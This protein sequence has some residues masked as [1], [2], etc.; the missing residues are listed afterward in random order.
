M[1]LALPWIQQQN[2]L[3]YPSSLL[4]LLSLWASASEPSS[5]HTPDVA[6]CCS[7]GELLHVVQLLGCQDAHALPA[8]PAL[9]FAPPLKRAR[10]GEVARGAA[11]LLESG[12]LMLCLSGIGFLI[13]H[14]LQVKLSFIRNIQNPPFPCRFRMGFNKGWTQTGTSPSKQPSMASLLLSRLLFSW[15]LFEINASTY[16]AEISTHR[17]R[18]KMPSIQ[19]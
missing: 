2:L 9:G 18:W 7:R 15:K 14:K 3:R 1:G 4:V 19:T 12:F 17:S 11:E 5:Q 10:E 16:L 8:K 6:A 13:E